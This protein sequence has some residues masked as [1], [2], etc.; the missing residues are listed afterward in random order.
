MYIMFYLSY[1]KWPITISNCSYE[2]GRI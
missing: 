2:N 1:V